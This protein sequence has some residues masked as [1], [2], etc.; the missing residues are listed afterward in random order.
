MKKIYAIFVIDNWIALQRKGDME[1][2]RLDA[3]S[4]PRWR[5]RIFFPG[6]TATFGS[7]KKWEKPRLEVFEIKKLQKFRYGEV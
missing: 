5:R 6:K 1:L 4:F 3:L 2:I 7:E